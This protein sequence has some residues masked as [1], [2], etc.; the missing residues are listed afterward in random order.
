M[1]NGPKIIAAKFPG[2][3]RACG[4]SFP[5]GARIEWQANTRPKHADGC[6]TKTASEP[7]RAVPRPVGEV[8]FSVT[9]DHRSMGKPEIDSEVG[10]TF[11]VAGGQHAGEVVTV[12]TQRRTYQSAEDNEDM[13]DCMG[14]GWWLHLGVRP[15]TPE[16]KAKLE[17]EEAKEKAAREAE[18]AAKKAAAAKKREEIEAAGAE[19]ARRTINMVR[20]ES[21]T[22]EILAPLTSG[23]TPETVVR[24]SLR[25]RQSNDLVQRQAVTG[26]TVYVL[27]SYDGDDDRQALY[28]PRSVVEASWK[29]LAAKHGE[30][31]E[32][33]KDFLS[34]YSNCVGSDWRRWL[35][36]QA[37]K[38]AAS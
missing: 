10:R 32:K 21:F 23:E 2:V 27:Y 5:A 12:L 20:T 28:A 26:E 15:A 24:W 17:T 35:I 30:T 22:F 3:C 36:A 18:Q 29:L 16:E 34:K 6:P 4:T 19:L 14:G 11:R 8:A 13:G 37:E 25:E 31:V 33:A 38:G 1:A 7:T 9:L